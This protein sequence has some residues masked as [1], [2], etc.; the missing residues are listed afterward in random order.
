MTDFKEF[1]KIARLNR[2]VII[3]EK[4]DGTN[5]SIFISEDLVEF[6]AASRTRWVT[7]ENDN[8]GFARWACEHE[9]EL[10][11]LGPGFHYGE[12]WGG[13]IQ[14]G[15][16]LERGEK[17][18]SLFNVGRWSDPAVR[19]ACCGIVPEIA[20]GPFMGPAIPA[21]L[22]RLAQ[23]GSLAAPGFM[24]PEGIIVFTTAGSH[25]FKVTLE[26]DEESKEARILREA[27]A[28]RNK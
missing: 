20:R 5:A 3:T 1:P 2:D 19:P 7:P 6:R 10:R 8:Y 15:Y 28:A 21:A 4:I 16:G 14:R 27:W 11:T 13:G 22:A 12:W 26:G 9:T 24:R 25:L 23:T 18:F 17:R